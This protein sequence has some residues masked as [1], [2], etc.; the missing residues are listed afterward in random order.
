MSKEKSVRL[1]RK[2]G[3]RG[4]D[5]DEFCTYC[6]GKLTSSKVMVCSACGILQFG[7]EITKG[8]IIMELLLWLGF[9]L[10]VVLWLCGQIPGF[11][12]LCG[13]VPFFFTMFSGAFLL[14]GIPG[15]I[16]SSWRLL[17]RYWGCI[18]CGEKT[19]IRVDSPVGKRLIAE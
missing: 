13:V 7:K 10:P 16:Y 8:S 2:C 11:F 19:L 17:S 9:L 5:S 14:F 15:L 18:S 6:G 3:L 12:W 4:K 1:C